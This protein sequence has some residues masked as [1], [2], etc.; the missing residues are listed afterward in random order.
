ML[1]SGH[2]RRAAFVLVPSTYTRDRV[3]DRLQVDLERVRLAPLGIDERFSPGEPPEGLRER[4]ELEGRYVLTVG[5]LQP[6]K[7]IEA[8]LTR[9]AA[10]R[11]WVGPRLAIVGRR[12]ACATSRS[13]S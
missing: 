6:R 5:T 11:R 2:V 13:Q 1:R 12:G 3:V 10:G 4:L 9:S 7:N 8:A